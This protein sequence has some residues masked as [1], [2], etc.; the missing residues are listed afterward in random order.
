MMQQKEALRWVNYKRVGKTGGS[1][2][3]YLPRIFT[4]MAGIGEGDR[5]K[6]VFTE[7][8]VT[9]TKAPIP[10]ETSPEEPKE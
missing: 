8:S 9:I 1:L 2:R 4:R 10:G 3:I 6:L 5:V 7:S